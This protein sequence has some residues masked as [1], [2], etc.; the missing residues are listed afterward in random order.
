[1]MMMLKA[2]R[3]DTSWFFF[4]Q[5]SLLQRPLSSSFQH[6]PLR[7]LLQKNRTLFESRDLDL[8]AGYAVLLFGQ[9]AGFVG[10]TTP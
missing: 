8:D 2:G 3:Y 9:S 6:V 5:D 4:L 1:M 10:G 7:Y